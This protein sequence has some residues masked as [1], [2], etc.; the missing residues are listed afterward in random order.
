MKYVQLVINVQ[1]GSGHDPETVL[2]ELYYDVYGEGV[3]DY[4]LVDCSVED[5]EQTPAAGLGYGQHYYEDLDRK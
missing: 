4:E 2:R 3:A 1:V 5:T